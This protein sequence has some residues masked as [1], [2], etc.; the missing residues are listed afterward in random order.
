MYVA[1]Q[2]YAHASVWS[3]I[4]YIAILYSEYL[5]RAQIFVNSAS[6]EMFT[7]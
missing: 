7:I 2:L 5:L 4:Y 3:A 1:T 6:E